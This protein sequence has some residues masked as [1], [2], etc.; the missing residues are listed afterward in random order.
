MA[1]Y[2][3]VERPEL[4]SPVL[5]LALDGWIDAAKFELGPDDLTAIAAAIE[6]TGAG[7]GPVK[8]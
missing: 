7:Q 1:L 6:A 3:L 4:G 2:D 5:V 8:P